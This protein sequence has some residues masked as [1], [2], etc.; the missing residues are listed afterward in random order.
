MAE[1]R[2]SQLSQQLNQISPADSVASK[3]TVSEEPLGT[4]RHVRVVCIGAGASG[5]NLIRTLRKQ[6]T[7]FDLVVYEKNKEIGGTWFENRY[8]GCKCDIPS[9]N[10]QFSWLPNPEWKEFYSSATEIQDYLHRCCEK[11]KLYSAIKT[12]HRVDHAEWNDSEGVWSL[13]IVDEK[14]GKKFHDHCHFLL[15][16]MGILK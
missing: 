13:R 14:S 7:N 3:Y 10:Y 6:A 9:H 16:G 15:D 5:I 1:E 12:S 2:L 4:A 8:P 11:E